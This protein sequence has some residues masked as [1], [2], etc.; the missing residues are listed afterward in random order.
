MSN[1]YNTIIVIV[2]TFIIHSAS[3]SRGLLTSISQ[4]GKA[5]VTSAFP[6]YL[7]P[8]SLATSML[9]VLRKGVAYVAILLL[10]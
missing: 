2:Y 3:V 6:F 1:T 10:F 8:P 5:L 4:K 9:P 7:E